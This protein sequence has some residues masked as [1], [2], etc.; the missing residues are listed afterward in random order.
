MLS[1]KKQVT[2]NYVKP[3]IKCWVLRKTYSMKKTFKK[4]GLIKDFEIQFQID[5]DK[6]I[7]FLKSDKNDLKINFYNKIF[8]KEIPFNS[9][10]FK[11]DSSQS[12]FSTNRESDINIHKGRAKIKF[13]IEPFE[14]KSTII[15]GKVESYYSDLKF[16]LIAYGIFISILTFAV[17]SNENYGIEWI[18]Y[19]TGFFIFVTILI[20]LFQKYEIC[21]AQ[22][23]L[24]NYFENK[25]TNANMV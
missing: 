25:I 4:L 3:K 20:I 15:S 12:E 23:A 11:F 7:D 2:V 24:M 9:S 18:L 8:G 21:K 13:K 22:K 5:A 19:I 1:I 10:D 14:N 6:V 17:I 16:V